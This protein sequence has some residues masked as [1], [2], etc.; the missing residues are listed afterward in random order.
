[1][2]CRSVEDYCLEKNKLLQ[3]FRLVP[4]YHLFSDIVACVP[5]FLGIC[6]SEGL[7]E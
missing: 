3:S 4:V 5:L 2:E 6:A 7:A 1:M